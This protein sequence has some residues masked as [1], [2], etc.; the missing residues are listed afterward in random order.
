MKKFVLFIMALIMICLCGCEETED[1]IDVSDEKTDAV[2]E[3]DA[4]VYKENVE[5]VHI[6]FDVVCKKGDNYVLKQSDEYFGYRYEVYDNHGNLMDRGIHS[7]RGFGIGQEENLVIL[8]DGSAGLFIPPTVKFYDVEKGRIS[9]FFLGPAQHYKEL[10]AYFRYSDDGETFL[11]VQNMFDS[12]KYYR[13]FVGEGGFEFIMKN[14]IK[15][16]FSQDGKKVTVEYCEQNNEE[17][18]LIETFSLK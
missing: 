10:V 17:N 4:E 6:S 7:G 9:P 5:D 15:I 18:I 8:V 13:E 3:S 2:S 16:E 14:I 12:S 11:V 1:K